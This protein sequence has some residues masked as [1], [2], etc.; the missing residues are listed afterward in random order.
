[1]PQHAAVLPFPATIAELSLEGPCGP[2]QAVARPALPGRRAAATA[3]ICHPHPLHGGSMQN[4]VVT[5]L[6]R[7]L[8][9]RGLDTV[10]FNFRGVGASAGHYD[11]GHGEGDDLACV[12]EW[13]RDGAPGQGLWLAGFSFGSYVSIRN[14]RRLRADALISVAPPVG[15]WPF[16]DI[17]L[18]GCPWWLIQGEQDEVVDPEAVYAWA[19]QLPS[20]PPLVR[21]PDTGHFFHG[22][23]LDL[24]RELQAAD[25]P[26]PP[27][28][29]AD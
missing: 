5:M 13:A 24:R 29:C 27:A 4:K 20:A 15:R 6:E 7:S 8:H 1:M 3:V 28:P 10:R 16:E 17:A 22:R 9:E 12:V 18:P 19:G 2:L 21:L 25:L 11:D 14:A 26:W 23:L